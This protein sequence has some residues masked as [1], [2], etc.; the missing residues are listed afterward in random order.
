[1][2]PT[3]APIMMEQCLVEETTKTYTDIDEFKLAVDKCNY[4]APLAQTWIDD[5]YKMKILEETDVRTVLEVIPGHLSSIFTADKIVIKWFHLTFDY[6]FAEP[7]IVYSKKARELSAFWLIKAYPGLVEISPEGL[8]NLVSSGK[9]RLDNPGCDAPYPDY[10]CALGCC[11]V[12]DEC[13]DVYLCTASSWLCNGGIGDD[14][15]TDECETC[16]SDAV[17]CVVGNLGDDCQEINSCYDNCRNEFF[18]CPG[19]CNFWDLSDEKCCGCR[20]IYEDTKKCPDGEC[21]PKD[22]CCVGERKCPDGSCRSLLCCDGE[23]RCPSGNCVLKQDSCCP[24]APKCIFLPSRT[25]ESTASKETAVPQVNCVYITLKPI[26]LHQGVRTIVT[27]RSK[28]KRT[29]VTTLLDIHT[30]YLL[31]LCKQH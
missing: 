26:V 8:D 22:S 9:R 6:A 15:C 13:Y 5:P 27:P 19:K 12:H 20:D 1:M 18:D 7:A 29:T 30:T 24:D 16:N 23:K 21:I 3:K 17:N 11:A 10:S 4:T 25:T 31:E 2:S 28:S 14:D